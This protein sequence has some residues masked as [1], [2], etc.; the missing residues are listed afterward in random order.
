ME[1]DK[2]NEEKDSLKMIFESMD[3]EIFTEDVQLKMQTLFESAVNEA[4]EKKEKELEEANAADLTV[5]KADLVEQI[6]DYM[7]YFVKDYIKENEVV[8]EDFS[9]VKLAEKVLRNFNQM[10]EA[11][12]ISL[13]DESIDAED[14]IEKLKT[15]CNK[16]TNNLI[17]SKKENEDIKRAAIISEASVGATDLQIEQLIETTKKLDFETLEIF[18]TKVKTIMEKIITESKSDDDEEVSKLNENVEEVPV[19]NKK[20]SVSQYLKYLK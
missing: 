13:S 7:D 15:E 16:L 18:E 2:L 1:D 4:V 8:V 12:N 10:V 17:E 9:K 20:T 6:D 5:F 14:E 3:K 11:F 19:E